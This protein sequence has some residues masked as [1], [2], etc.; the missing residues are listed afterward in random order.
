[1][2]KELFG[3]DDE[4]DNVQQSQQSIVHE[5]QPEP[6][7]E[8]EKEDMEK[9]T[10]SQSIKLLPKIKKRKNKDGEEEGSEREKRKLTKEKKKKRQPRPTNEDKSSQRP[11][12]EDN[13]RNQSETVNPKVK[14]AQND[15][16]AALESIKP[17]K[18][19]RH[20]DDVLYDQLVDALKSK[21]IKAAEEDIHSHASGQPAIEKLKLLPTVIENLEKADLHE[22]IFDNNL[23]EAVRIWLEPFSDGSLPNL[24]IRRSLLKSLELLPIDKIQL[25]ESK[26]GQIV[27]FLAKHPTEQPEIKKLALGLVNKWIRPILGH[28]MSYRD[29]KRENVPVNESVARQI[30]RG[31]LYHHSGSSSSSNAPGEYKKLTN[32]LKQLKSLNK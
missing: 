10:S 2:E 3:S 6:A 24:T 7:K 4:D 20:K 23:L 16:E 26:L 1:M 11:E 25:Q 27:M 15:F 31:D 18:R 30:E 14:E 22:Y 19:T 9:Q 17:R 12:N 28:S 29:M 21:M 13:E 8:A 32:K 5:P